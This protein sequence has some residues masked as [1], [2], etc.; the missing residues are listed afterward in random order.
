MSAAAEQFSRLL[1]VLPAFAERSTQ[2]LDELAARVGVPPEVI[3]A[4]LRALAERY[5]APAGHL[6]A[7]GVLIEREQVTVR[8]NHFLRPMRVT[9]A[10]LC[11]LELGLGVL[12]REA[13]GERAAALVRLRAKLAECITRLPHDAVHEGIRAGALTGEGAAA[14]LDPLREA[15]RRKRVVEVAYHGPNDEAPGRR[16]VRPHALFFRH[17]AWYLAGHCERSDGLRLFRA[18]RIAQVAVTDRTHEPP[19]VNPDDFLQDGRAWVGGNGAGTMQVRYSAGIARWIAER[20]GLPLEADGSAV[21]TMPLAD[22]EWAIRHL[23]QYGPDATIEAPDD[24]AEEVRA[25]LA[26][27]SER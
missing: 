27:M 19:P 11:A 8:T 26:A 12:A 6:E 25:R 7:V 15:L 2:R 17:G 4:D 20:D 18:D 5:D 22:R 23:L 1:L 10:E 16:T 3:V 24:L 13:D 21:R 14:V 9:V